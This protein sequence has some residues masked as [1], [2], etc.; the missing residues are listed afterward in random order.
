MYQMHKI[1]GISDIRTECN[2]GYLISDQI[3]E[4][5]ISS[6]WISDTHFRVYDWGFRKSVF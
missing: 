5:V 1:T 2:I 3:S 4:K 6:S